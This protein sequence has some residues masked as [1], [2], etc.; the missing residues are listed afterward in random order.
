MKAGRERGLTRYSRALVVSSS[1]L[2]RSY[3][4]GCGMAGAPTPTANS[5]RGRSSI[6]TPPHA[7][8]VYID[9]DNDQSRTK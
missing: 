2:W 5:M 4:R 1:A 3:I 6:L 9:F 7:K 8:F